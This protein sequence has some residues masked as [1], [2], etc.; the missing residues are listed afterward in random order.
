MSRQLMSGF[1]AAVLSALLLAYGAIGH[2]E[3]KTTTLLASA[4]TAPPAKKARPARN[5][6]PQA[7]ADDV[8]D[9]EFLGRL[10]IAARDAGAKVLS[11]GDSC[12]DFV[13]VAQAADGTLFAAYAAYYDGHDQIRLHRRLPSGRWSTRTHV[14]LA[15]ANADIWMPQLA[16]DSKNRLW[17]IWSEQ[18]GQ[19]AEKTGN[20]DLYARSLVN[21]TWGPLVRLSTDPKPDIN[22]HVA[23]DSQ[24]NIHVV[25]QAHPKNAGDIYYCKF[26]GENWSQPLAVTS[27]AESD[28]F[29][30]VAVDK[31]GTAWIAFDSYR[32]GDYDVFL[33]TVRDGR[34]GKVIPI[35]TSSY[36]E[37]HASVACGRDGAVWVAWEQG[38]ANWGKDV[39]YWLHR[40]NRN[41]GSSLGSTR[42]VKVACY[43]EGNVLAAPDVQ[44]SLTEPG[45]EAPSTD[46]TAMATLACGQDGRVWLRFRRMVFAP[47]RRGRPRG[48]KGWVESVTTLSPNGWNPAVDLAASTGRI[49]V[50]SR[51]LPAKDGSLWVAYSSDA[52]DPRNYHRP[53]QDVA[54]VTNIPAPRTEIGV[55]K[56]AAYQ[57]PDP[58]AGIPAWNASR[59]AKQVERIRGERVTIEGVEHRIV[60]GDLHRHTEMSWDVGPGNDGSYLDFYR[61]MIDVASMDFGS[62]TDHQGGGHYAYWWWLT[63]KSAD[64]YFLQPRFVPLYGYERSV[65]FPNGHRN[66]FHAVRGIPVFPF[67]LKLDQTGVFPGIGTGQVVSNDTKLLYDFLS[68]TGGLC[69]PHTSGTSTMGTDWRDNDPSIEPVVEMYQ[70]ARNSYETL[71]APRVPL[72]TE[73]PENA[74]GGFQQAGLVW[75]AYNKGYR[76]GTISSSDHGSTHISYALVYTPSNERQAV[77][78]S[79]R[80]RHTY[81]ATDNIVLDFRANGHFMGD[82]FTTG[83]RPNF[84]LHAIGTEKIAKISLIRDNEYLYTATPQQEQTTLEYTDEHPKTGH[85]ALYYVRL[86]QTDGQLA[87]SSPVW[88][89]CTR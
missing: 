30:S 35:A 80:K 8:T 3:T 89:T 41:Q 76:L 50:F 19:S 58:P 63:Q 4:D 10:E 34:P 16:V 37:A 75:K 9:A 55:P 83:E 23:I 47:Q 82:E 68:R 1:S 88:I 5:R 13:S 60:R 42:H 38:G 70:G 15:R 56:L 51:I 61:Y 22:P 62:L 52:R 29:P 36:Y 31:D 49:S 53:I 25:W 14:P 72:N 71:G 69:I 74:P 7:G 64:M 57:P 33:T 54:L 44:K 84:T 67:Q 45:A 59:E 11:T 20:W 46:E 79:I 78:D 73:K 85:V 43:R 86:E 39:G 17:V 24:R 48:Q 81:G 21:D 27:D 2:R 77:L 87:W 66:V 12:D 18:T 65:Q 40:T 28:W 32:N 6:T 26:D